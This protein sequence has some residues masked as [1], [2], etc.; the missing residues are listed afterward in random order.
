MLLRSSA[1]RAKIQK[2]NMDEA[3]ACR[4]NGSEWAL[5]QQAGS[6]DSPLDEGSLAKIGAQRNLAM[7]QACSTCQILSR[8]WECEW[9]SVDLKSRLL[10]KPT[11]LLHGIWVILEIMGH[12]W[13][14]RRGIQPQGPK[15]GRTS[16]PPPPWWV[17]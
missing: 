1:P 8:V 16:A 11:L 2:L 3:H 14:I 12:Y 13:L 6:K 4:L 7:P 15:L 5:L 10:M 17:A 9:T